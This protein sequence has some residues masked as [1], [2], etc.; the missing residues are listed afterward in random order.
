MVEI[1]SDLILGLGQRDLPL[2]ELEIELADGIAHFSAL[3]ALNILPSEHPF[4]T[5]ALHSGRL[6]LRV[7]AIDPKTF[8]LGAFSR[9]RLSEAMTR[10][11]IFPLSIVPRRFSI[12]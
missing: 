6:S 1:E 2:N 5:Q 12:P 8:D 9:N 3:E 4:A 7:V 10:L 11:A